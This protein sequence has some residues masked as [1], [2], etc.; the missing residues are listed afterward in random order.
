MRPQ[1]SAPRRVVLLPP[2]SGHRPPF[3]SF[4][5]FQRR[6]EKTTSCVGTETAPGCLLHV[7]K[8]CSSAHMES[9][10]GAPRRLSTPFFFSILAATPARFFFLKKTETKG[11]NQT[12]RKRQNGK[13]H[14]RK[15]RG[16]ALCI[17]RQKGAA[18]SFP[19]R[20]FFSM[21]DA[22]GARCVP[23]FFFSTVVFQVMQRQKCT[24]AVSLRLFFFSRHLAKETLGEKSTTSIEKNAYRGKRQDFEKGYAKKR[25]HSLNILYCHADAHSRQNKSPFARVSARQRSQEETKRVWA[26]RCAAEKKKVPLSL[27]FFSYGRP[28]HRSGALLG[29]SCARAGRR[30]TRRRAC[31]RASRPPFSPPV[32]PWDTRARAPTGA[33]LGGRHRLPSSTSTSP[34]GSR[35]CAAFRG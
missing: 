5:R 20:P 25:V 35:R 19:Q 21:R 12:E 16:V 9:R 26:W 32:C 15:K 18:V 34:T 14:A 24:Y 22:I 29:F 6:Q 4:F 33:S 10:K 8:K 1:D 28:T 7:A 3:F 23:L 2:R 13:E 31:G 30:S 27:L 11:K 17:E